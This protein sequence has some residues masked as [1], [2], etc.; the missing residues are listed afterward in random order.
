[1]TVKLEGSF[2]I[3]T[4]AG[5]VTSAGL[6][7]FTLDNELLQW[8]TLRT[9]ESSEAYYPVF[10]ILGVFR[11]NGQPKRDGSIIVRSC[12]ASQSPVYPIRDAF[13]VVE[14]PSCPFLSSSYP[15][16]VG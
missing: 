16:P 4:Y 3:Y 1:M 10:P 6:Q 12:K 5:S 13:A 8:G 9:A 2:H 14:H 11:L 15:L 7:T